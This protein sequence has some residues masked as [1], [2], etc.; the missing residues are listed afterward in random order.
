MLKS[1]GGHQLDTAGK[2]LLDTKANTSQGF[3]PLEYYIIRDNVGPLL[4]LE[5]CL[6]KGG[7]GGGG[8]GLKFITIN[9]TVEQVG[10]SI[11][12]VQRK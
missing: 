5:S 7:G 3:T 6:R 2:R 12:D 4:G 11:D 9:D 8:W 10:L 1:F